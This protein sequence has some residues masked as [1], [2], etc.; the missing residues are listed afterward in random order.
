MAQQ[1][2]DGGS[3]TVASSFVA[4]VPISGVGQALVHAWKRRQQQF[5][6]VEVWRR[7][8]VP[9]LQEDG[10]LC[11]GQGGAEQHQVP[12]TVLHLHG[13]RQDAGQPLLTT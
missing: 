6:F 10:V 7:R 5:H 1:R 13:L 4:D 2:D 3:Y 12:Q 9:S 8:Q 11:G